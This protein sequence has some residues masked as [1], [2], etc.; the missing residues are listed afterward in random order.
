MSYVTWALRDPKTA[1]QILN[2]KNSA[3][4]DPECETRPAWFPAGNDRQ[5][6]S[7]RAIA[8]WR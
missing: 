6:V 4:S 2:A 3:G 5:G 8:V 7:L 1:K